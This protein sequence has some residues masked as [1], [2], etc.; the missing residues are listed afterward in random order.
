MKK[1]SQIENQTEVQNEG[2]KTTLLGGLAALSMMISSCQ[3]ITPEEKARLKSEIEELNKQEEESLKKSDFYDEQLKRLKD[4]K[5]NL[6][7]EI[8]DAKKS[9]GILQSGNTPRYIIKLHFQ[10]DNFEN[11]YIEFDFEIPVDEK[12]YNETQVGEKLAKGERVLSWNNGTV[13]VVEKRIE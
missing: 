7:S 5:S 9:L 13:K 11:D 1:F 8:S 10:E 3:S 2:I 4:E 12:F 6:E